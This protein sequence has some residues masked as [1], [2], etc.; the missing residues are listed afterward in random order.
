[1]SPN[2][3]CRIDFVDL[4]KG[5]TIFLVVVGHAIQ[6]FSADYDQ[7][8]FFRLIY[9]FHMPLFMFLGGYLTRLE[10][11]TGPEYI[12]KK[13]SQLVVPFIFWVPV[14]YL[15]VKFIQQPSPNL[16]TFT[17]FIWQIL[18][19]PDAGGLWFLIV[20]FECHLMLVLLRPLLMRSPLIATA[21]VV[22]G[23]NLL[24]MM[25]PSSNWLGLGLLRWYLLYFFAGVLVRHWRVAPPNPK[26]GTI[27]GL[28]FLLLASLWMRKGAW[29]VDFWFPGLVG[30]RRQL[31]V[32]GYHLLTAAMGIAGLWSLASWYQ[33]RTEILRSIWIRLGQR[34]IQIYAG[35]YFFL[36]VAV[37]CSVYFDLPSGVAIPMITGMA[38]GGAL[39]LAT[40]LERLPLMQRIAFGR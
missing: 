3:I 17:S 38:L 37:N 12:R 31:L 25:F 9:A 18:R 29:P 28:L 36:Y 26:L 20:L 10:T 4:L 1:M 14:S 7:N 24:I 16:T 30:S 15:A 34:S 27:I 6:Y 39:L 33:P 8:F 32:Q 19:N 11:S 2:S 5:W 23:L 22:F 40:I 21:F 13:L 35:H